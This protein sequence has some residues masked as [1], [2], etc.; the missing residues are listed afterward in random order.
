MTRHGRFIAAGM[1]AG[2]IG[3]PGASPAGAATIRDL[4]V[5]DFFVPEGAGHVTE[6]HLAA[7]AARPAPTVVFIQDAHA[8]PQA[9]RHVA[10]ILR[11]LVA[12]FGLGLVLVEGGEGDVSPTALREVGTREARQH[13]AENYLS[14]GLMSGHEY[15]AMLDE[16]PL[17]LWGIDDAARYREHVAAF[18]EVERLREAWDGPLAALQQAADALVERAGSS[19]L[20]RLLAARQ[21]YAD[22]RVPL[23]DYL[24]ALLLEDGTE[25]VKELFKV[26]AT[27]FGD[28]TELIPLIHAAAQ[29][30]HIDLTPE[31]ITEIFARALATW[32][33]RPRHGPSRAGSLR[34]WNAPAC[35]AR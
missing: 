1:A 7:S 22:G 10:E 18:L 27:R 12:D 14:L 21:G 5:S 23:A 6:R 29:R 24:R 35:A 15:V 31:Q 25:R 11:Q 26:D 20:Q 30:E 4:T 2:M 33:T 28:T 3:W 17:T 32:P 19:A 9:Q 13:V 34:S 16:P 8:D